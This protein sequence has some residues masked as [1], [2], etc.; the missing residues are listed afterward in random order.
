MTEAATSAP[1]RIDA[2]HHLWRY[3][4]EEFGWI[5]DRS[6][7]LRRDFLVPE[8]SHELRAA[9]VS[10]CIAVQAPQTLAET[11]V[12]LAAAETANSPILGV[13][14]W[15]PLA[16]PT[17]PHI[18]TPYLRREKLK[19]LRHILQAEPAG[20]LSS[21]AFNRGIATLAGTGLVFDLLLH[22]GQ[23]REAISF[24]DR[25]PSQ[26]FVLDHLGKPPIASGQLEPWRTHLTELSLRPHVSCKLSGMATEARWADRPRASP[27]TLAQSLRPFVDAALAAFSPARLMIGSDWPVLT[28]DCTYAQWWHT[29]E[30][31]LAPLTS[32]EQAAILG[33]TA[34]R[35]YS[36]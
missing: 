24:V 22:A 31:W 20:F 28:V 14:G 32:T 23:L 8:L 2:H 35:I 5:D 18:L 1:P 4:P 15:L 10:G 36:L 27:G 26:L 13:V 16:D 6:A 19:G 3:T 11:D 30:T 29:V 17:F 7:A 9:N 33:N 21:P 34:T 25:H 12:L